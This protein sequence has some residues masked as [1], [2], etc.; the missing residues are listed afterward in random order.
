MDVDEPELPAP[1]NWKLVVAVVVSGW[2][3]EL[4]VDADP[5]RNEGGADNVSGFGVAFAGAS[6]FLMRLVF[7]SFKIRSSRC[8]L[9]RLFMTIRL[10]DVRRGRIPPDRKSVV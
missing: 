6:I 9:S 4:E 2:V 1:P 3:L 5:G 10:E 8:S 7:K